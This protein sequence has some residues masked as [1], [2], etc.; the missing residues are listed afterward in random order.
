MKSKKRVNKIRARD[1]FSVESIKAKSA[2]NST[3]AD[4]L[5]NLRCGEVGRIS[6]TMITEKQADMI[7]RSASKIA[8]VIK[9]ARNKG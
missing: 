2:R 7:L 3:L 9:I 5:D 8:E 4:I 1:F 6:W